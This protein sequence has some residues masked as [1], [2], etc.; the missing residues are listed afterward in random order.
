MGKHSTKLRDVLA[1]YVVAQ[2]ECM[3]AVGFSS[4][5]VSTERKDMI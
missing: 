4:E 1:E 5:F 2:I 3:V